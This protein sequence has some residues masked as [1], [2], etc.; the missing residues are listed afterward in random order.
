MSEDS[1]KC[2][3]YLTDDIT[4]F[5]PLVMIVAVVCKKKNLSKIPWINRKRERRQ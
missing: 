2:F 5:F 4:D 3:T 1:G